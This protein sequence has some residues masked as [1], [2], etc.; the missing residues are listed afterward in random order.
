MSFPQSWVGFDSLAIT[1]W[2]IPDPAAFSWLPMT[3]RHL[4]RGLLT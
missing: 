2:T 3:F 1:A 4:I